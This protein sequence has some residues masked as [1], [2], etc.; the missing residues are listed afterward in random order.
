MR[1]FKQWIAAA[2]FWQTIAH[3][4]LGQ[5]LPGPL[6]NNVW[7]GPPA[8]GLRDDSRFFRKDTGAA[9][10]VSTQLR[11]LAEEHG[12]RIYL[13]VEP[14]LLG[15]TAPELAGE[16][17]QAWLPHGD[18]LV[19]VFEADSRSLGFGRD[20]D[21]GPG[22]ESTAAQVPT[23][24]TAAILQ[25]VSESTDA[26]LPPDV[27]LET[28]L[29]NLTREFSGYFE[30]RQAPPPAGRSMRLA[31][32]TLGALALLALAG[33]AIGALARLPSMAGRQT[34]RFP[35]VDRPERLGAPCGGGNVTSRRFKNV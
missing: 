4:G 32:L 13:L 2:V 14:V 11:K 20:V 33:I 19:V 9:D 10:R 27:F 6:E 29:G 26:Q 7:G 12:F 30:R 5:V 8:S 22:A 21:G 25:R 24:Q 34:F 31:L 35:E 23:H 3:S 18:G 1:W 17:Q 28:L 16:L 15:K